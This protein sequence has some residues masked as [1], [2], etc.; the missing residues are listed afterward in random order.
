MSS[1]VEFVKTGRLGKLHPGMTTSQFHE[2]LGGP[3]ERFGPPNPWMW[4]SGFVQLS[5]NRSASDPELS[6]G[7][8]TLKP[9]DASEPVHA[10]FG[11]DEGGSWPPSDFE[12][13]R[14]WLDRNGIR[15][16][17]GN[18]YGK[19]RHLVLESGVRVEFDEEGLHTVRFT[20]K[21]ETESRQITVNL[22]KTDLEL[23]KREAAA[24]G[25]SVSKICSEWIREHV[26]SL[27]R[28]EVQTT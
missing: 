2:F 4:K 28:Q 23:A 26:A 1:F 18:V 27:G 12:G 6:I 13:F 9:R 16:T 15:T 19:D 24:R 5:F 14:A 8:I 25:L 20:P 3:P 11:W 10:A 21:R 22:S 17:G 7:S